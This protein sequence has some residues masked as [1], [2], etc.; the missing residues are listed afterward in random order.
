[1]T[2]EQIAERRRE[3]DE[4]KAIAKAKRESGAGGAYP[5]SRG[6]TI[7]RWHLTWFV[8]RRHDPRMNWRFPL[9]S[10]PGAIGVAVLV[11]V[12]IAPLA[13]A[14]GPSEPR[15]AWSAAHP[16]LGPGVTMSVIEG[17]PK[18]GPYT[19]HVRYPAG[20]TVGPHKHKIAEHVTVLSGTLLLGWGKVWDPAKFK[21]LR[22]GEEVVVPAGVVHFSAAREPTVMKITMTGLY[23]IEYVLEADDP[24]EGKR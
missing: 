4:I 6:G 5:L 8:D 9:T 22:A 16:G 7:A 14:E 24:R 1:M 12:G 15:G 2:P 17:N 19:F 11:L 18:T 20:H 23:D 10:L 3:Y 21:E 13:T